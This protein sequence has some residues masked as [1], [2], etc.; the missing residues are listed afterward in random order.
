VGL[1]ARQAEA[2]GISTLCL[3]TA[4][5]ILAAVKP[6]RAAF[7]DF[8]M[9][10]TAGPANIPELQRAILLAALEA[11]TSLTEPGSIKNLAF[12]WSENPAWKESAFINHEMK[13]DRNSTPQF[14]SV[15]DRLRWEKGDR[16]ALNCKCELCQS[17]GFQ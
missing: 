15:E 17:E 16:S 4:R 6:P 3:G 13:V 8:P 2:A 1:V 14:Q 10:F 5:D 12:E 7:L 9:G 11:F